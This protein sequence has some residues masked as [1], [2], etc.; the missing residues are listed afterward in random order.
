MYSCEL[1]DST[2]REGE[3]APGVRFSTAARLRII[4]GLG[5]VGVDEIELGAASPLHSWLPELVQ[6]A[7]AL[8]APSCRLALWCRC[9]ADDISF[10]ATCRP[11]LLSLS[12]PVPFSNKS[13]LVDVLQ[14][15]DSFP[16]ENGQSIIPILHPASVRIM[17]VE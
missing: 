13:R 4:A 12:I 1:I 6:Q 14:E 17:K 9:R 3:Q 7:R 15:G 5:Q 10:A 16:I 8:T 2:L 11:D